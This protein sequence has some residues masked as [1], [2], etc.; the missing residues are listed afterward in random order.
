MGKHKPHNDRYKRILFSGLHC[1]Y[2]CFC[3][4]STYL[5]C[6]N[7]KHLA[8]IEHI[9]P[10]DHGGSKIDRANMAISCYNCNQERGT[11]DFIEFKKFKQGFRITPPI[12]SNR[13]S[14]KRNRTLRNKE[15]VQNVT[16]VQY[17][18]NQKCYYRL[19]NKNLQENVCIN[20]YYLMSE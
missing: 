9:I 2:C 3:G 15:F 5:N 20:H 1:I 8:T 14:I 19:I 12:L 13:R 18:K 17:L 11:A 7:K 4:T 16:S 10:M 6:H